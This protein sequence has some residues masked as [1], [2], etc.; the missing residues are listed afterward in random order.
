MGWAFGFDVLTHE[1]LVSVET[2]DDKIQLAYCSSVFSK[3][4]FNDSRLYYFK[5]L[6][7]QVI[8]K[9]TTLILEIKVE[10]EPTEVHWLKD[11]A[12][13]PKSVNAKIEKIDDQT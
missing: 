13:I 7:F 11:G 9:G 2:G 10:G 5:N 8:A 1:V 12:A 6:L 4:V 3:G